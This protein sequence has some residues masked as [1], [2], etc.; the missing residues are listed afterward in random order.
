M[1][2]KIAGVV[3]VALGALLVG[4]NVYNALF[5]GTEFERV[6]ISGDGESVV[7]NIELTPDMNPVRALVRAKY[8][9]SWSSGDIRQDTDGRELRAEV[10]MLDAEGKIVWEDAVDFRRDSEEERRGR[11]KDSTQYLRTFD[12]TEAGQYSFASNVHVFRGSLKEIELVFKQN[13]TP[14]SVPVVVLGV[15]LVL[16]GLIMTSLD[17]IKLWLSE[18]LIRRPKSS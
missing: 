4:Y 2:V 3:C 7:E 15:I 6:A 17:Q 11:T 5:T 1:K 16:A 18:N 12:V 8:E 10:T 13:V 14:L 9:I